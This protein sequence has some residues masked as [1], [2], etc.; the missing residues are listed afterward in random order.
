MA[1][2]QRADKTTATRSILTDDPDFLRFIVERVVQEVLEAEMTA[3]L[4]AEPYERN[5]TRSGYRN[6]YKLR[7]LNTRAMA[8]HLAVTDCIN[9]VGQLPD[10]RF[11]DNRRRLAHAKTGGPIASPLARTGFAKERKRCVVLR[12]LL[13]Q[14]VGLSEAVMQRAKDTNERAL[15]IRRSAWSRC[16]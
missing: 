2:N 1:Y 13:H 3:H 10:N 5:L 12:R 11:A 4:H 8:D 15:K 6:G 9:L 16:G 7:Q 14:R